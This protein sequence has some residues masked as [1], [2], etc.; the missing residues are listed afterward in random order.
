MQRCRR[1]WIWVCVVCVHIS[2]V[3]IGTGTYAAGICVFNCNDSGFAFELFEEVESAVCI[4]DIVI[5]KFFAG[6]LF[7]SGEGS[8]V[9]T[10]LTVE[11]SAL[12]GIFAVT[13][14]LNFFE[15]EGKAVGKGRFIE[16]FSEIIG[17]KRI[18]CCGMFEN[19]ESELFFSLKADAAVLELIDNGRIICGV[20][21]NCNVGMVL[22]SGTDHCGAADVDI[23]DCFFESST[24]FENGFLEGVEVDG[25]DVDGFNAE[26]FDLLHMLGIISHSK[27]ACMDHGVKGLYATVETFRET[28][29]VADV[30]N[31][32]TVIAK[33][34][35]GT[36]G[37]KDLEAER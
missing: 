29:N 20:N 36:A 4:V 10:Y 24:F 8:V 3:S 32:D 27:N 12:V 34:S 25:D 17:D 16:L 13:H 23:F 14:A 35:R 6:K 2:F 22:C 26:I 9:M 18:V 1:K 7:G 5:R 30:G 31:V 19:F 15:S 21:D 11:S 28:G 37:G 33:R